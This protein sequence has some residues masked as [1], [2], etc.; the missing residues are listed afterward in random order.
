MTKPFGGIVKAGS[1]VAHDPLPNRDSIESLPR[2]SVITIC[3]N[4][5]R[6]IDRTLASVAECKYPHLQYIVVDGGSTDGTLQRLEKHAWHID[7]FISEPDDGISDALN[8]GVEA[9]DG[10]FHIVVHADDVLISESL[11]VL[12]R[13]GGSTETKVVCGTALVLDKNRVVRT[14]SARPAQL[15]QK[16]SLPHMGALIR[17]DAWAAVGK[18]DVRRKVAMD[19]LL[20]LRIYKHFGLR[21]FA[22]VDEI[23][24]HYF[25][26]GVSDAQADRGF[27]ELRENLIEEG[28][29]RIAA[30]S[31]YFLL[32]LKSKI[33]R[34]IGRT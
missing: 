34:A 15:R 9:S 33:A 18:Y 11:E 13:Y 19:H 29:G 21:S 22:V 27:L 12:A 26:G 30:T 17:K 6:T 24:A 32:L 31:A 14:F 3:K 2:I 4:A 5:I 16:M 7:R 28:Y 23:V 8:K 1:A 20:M 10:D 25:L